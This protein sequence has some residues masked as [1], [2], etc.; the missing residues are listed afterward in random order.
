[1]NKVIFLL[2]P[3]FHIKAAAGE[4]IHQHI[5]LL[6]INVSIELHWRFQAE[7]PVFLPP[8]LVTWQKVNPLYLN[9]QFQKLVTHCFELFYVAIKTGYYRYAD[10]QSRTIICY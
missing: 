4:N 10:Y 7:I 6:F 8:Q 2:S 1:M 9:V 3:F 5:D